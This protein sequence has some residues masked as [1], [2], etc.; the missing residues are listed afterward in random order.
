MHRLGVSDN[1]VRI[2][3]LKVRRFSDDRQAVLDELIAA[4]KAVRP[5][6]VIAPSL[7]DMHQDHQVVAQEA[8]RAFKNGCTILGWGYPW[9][10]KTFDTTAFI[11][12]EEEDLGRKIAAIGEYRSQRKPYMEPEIIR[13]WALTSGV[14]VGVRYAECFEVARL[15]C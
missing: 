3:Y 13:A 14:A 8:L 2:S 1:R 7:R 11:Q 12:F 9:N 4:R 15:V 10:I 5:D 6:L